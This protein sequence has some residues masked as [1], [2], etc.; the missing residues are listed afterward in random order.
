MGH[1]I[2]MYNLFMHHLSNIYCFSKEIFA[3]SLRGRYGKPS[4]RRSQA[5]FLY[6]LV[7]WWKNLGP[8]GFV[9]C[10]WGQDFFVY[11][12]NDGL[13]CSINS[14]MD[15][16][17]WCSQV[18]PSEMWTNLQLHL[19]GMT[20]DD[21]GRVFSLEQTLLPRPD[22][23]KYDSVDDDSE[24]EQAGMVHLTLRCLRNNWIRIG[25]FEFQKSIVNRD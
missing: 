6:S 9:P 2:I 14:W 3:G 7:I 4:A 21:L 18:V 17:N 13:F 25:I 12:L 16:F 5:G 20:W 15:Q 1:S 10:S 19:L 23:L 24:P 22:W 8:I 11:S